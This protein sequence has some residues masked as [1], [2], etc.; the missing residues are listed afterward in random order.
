MLLKDLVKAKENKKLFEKLLAGKFIASTTIPILFMGFILPKLIFASSA[1][2]IQNLR[3]KEAQ[4]LKITLKLVFYK[5][6]DFI[7]QKMLI[8]QEVG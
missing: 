7:N 2:K 8:L 6:T 5:K 1:K 3:E 4:S